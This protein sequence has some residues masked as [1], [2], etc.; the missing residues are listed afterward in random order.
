[1]RVCDLACSRPRTN[2]SI[3]TK[4]A[5]VVRYSLSIFK[6]LRAT[7]YVCGDGWDLAKQRKQGAKW[8]RKTYTQLAIS[9]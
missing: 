4:M 5:K 9:Y 6:K 7:V 2:K 8:I 1:M 3:G